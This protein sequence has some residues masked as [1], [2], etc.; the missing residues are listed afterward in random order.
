MRAFR[1][2]FILP[3]QAGDRAYD[4]T[5]FAVVRLSA[6]C[7]RSLKPAQLVY[8]D[9]MQRQEAG[10]CKSS[11]SRCHGTQC[12]HR[13]LLFSQLCTRPEVHAHNVI[14]ITSNGTPARHFSLHGSGKD[15]PRADSFW[16]TRRATRVLK[17][18]M[19]PDFLMGCNKARRLCNGRGRLGRLWFGRALP[20]H[21]GPSTVIQ[22]PLKQAALT[23][24][25]KY[26]E[27]D[28]EEGLAQL[29]ALLQKFSI[30][31]FRAYRN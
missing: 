31:K 24:A 6:V 12:S 17:H 21:N 25:A 10:S 19:G 18:S 11:E 3:L 28:S 9:T 23:C 7:I 15:P 1:W 16:G 30:N 27:D 14:T 5:A 22:K 2:A 8:I 29:T 20:T 26:F 4:Q 13:A